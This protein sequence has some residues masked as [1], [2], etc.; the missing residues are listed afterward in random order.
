MGVLEAWQQATPAGQQDGS[1]AAKVRALCEQAAKD[2][3]GQ[4]PAYGVMGPWNTEGGIAYHIRARMAH[5]WAGR[6]AETFEQ[7]I[8]Q[9]FAMIALDVFAFINRH[10]A[11]PSD[12]AD[13]QEQMN[14]L[15]RD[16]TEVLL[17]LPGTPDPTEDGNNGG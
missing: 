3:T 7:T 8:A 16:A 11:T 12:D 14:D 6:P 17:G 10:L 1:D 13:A 9:F 5:A 2:F 15:L 4:N